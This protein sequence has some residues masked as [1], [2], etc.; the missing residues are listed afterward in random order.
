MYNF[1]EESKATAIL[2][3][4]QIADRDFDLVFVRGQND[5][6]RETDLSLIM[7]VFHMLKQRISQAEQE[8][9]NVREDDICL[10]LMEALNKFRDSL[11]RR[12]VSAS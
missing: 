2:L 6:N 9:I 5:S 12:R 10:T 7:D 3:L 8:G 4:A 11:E 1:S